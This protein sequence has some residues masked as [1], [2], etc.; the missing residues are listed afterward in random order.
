M[1]QGETM[2]STVVLDSFESFTGCLRLLLW[3]LESCRSGR[4]LAKIVFGLVKDESVWFSLRFVW[5]IPKKRWYST[6]NLL[7]IFRWWSSWILRM[8]HCTWRR[9]DLKGTFCISK[10]LTSRVSR[11]Y[12]STFYIFWEVSAWQHRMQFLSVWNDE[13][14]WRTK[15]IWTQDKERNLENIFMFR[16][17]R[18]A[19]HLNR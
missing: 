13:G 6:G 16:W 2:N 5:C 14:I 10:V 9:L 18:W 8:C 3:R 15:S 17:F 11:K 4:D 1:S 7:N 19:I 12:A